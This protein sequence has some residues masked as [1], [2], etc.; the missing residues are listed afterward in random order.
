MFSC[1][2]AELG[3][4]CDGEGRQCA[5]AVPEGFDAELCIFNEG[6]HDCTA[7]DYSERSVFFAG[8]DDTRNCSQCECSQTPTA[9]CTNDYSLHA[10]ADCSGATIGD[11][12]PGFTCM[13]VTGGAA[14]QVNFTGDPG[15][16]LAV[17]PM[18]IGEVAPTGAVTYCCQ[19]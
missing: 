2:G 10:E 6:E 3:E 11:P 18:P 8:V 12:V 15:C 14:I 5:G 17:P 16:P 1:R 4:T 9:T 19:D 13:D 7:G